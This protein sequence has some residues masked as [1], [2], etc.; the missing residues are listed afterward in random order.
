MLIVRKSEHKTK[1]EE[2]QKQDEGQKMLILI[3]MLI[4]TP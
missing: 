2:G 3:E 4:G 1:I